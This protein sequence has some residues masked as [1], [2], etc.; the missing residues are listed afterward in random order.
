MSFAPHTLWS[1][2]GRAF[3]A[4]T[5]LA[6]ARFAHARVHLGLCFRAAPLLLLCRPACVHDA[7]TQYVGAHAIQTFLRLVR[8]ESLLHL[9]F[10]FD[11]CVFAYPACCLC[12]PILSVW[13][14][15]GYAWN[16]CSPS[17]Q[18]RCTAW[19]ARAQSHWFLHFLHCVCV[20]CECVCLQ[21]NRPTSLLSTISVGALF[22]FI[23]APSVSSFSL[24]S[25]VDLICCDS[26]TRHNCGTPTAVHNRLHLLHAFC[27]TSIV[28]IACARAL[29]PHFRA[30]RQ[31]I[32]F[33][34]PLRHCARASRA[35]F[36]ACSSLRA[37]RPQSRAHLHQRKCFHSVMW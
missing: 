7:P 16:L 35:P 6:L 36:C 28:D 12:F 4:L 33:I 34:S 20:W 22:C 37:L 26:R 23:L 27:F 1:P 9:S 25:S 31:S 32:P 24:A 3:P 2:C 11:A 13:I 19:T 21:T 17:Q 29:D 15:F 14:C 8:S 5:P 30:H 18:D 10:F